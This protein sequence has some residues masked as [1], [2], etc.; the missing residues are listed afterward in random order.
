VKLK[1]LVF[2]DEFG[3]TTHMTRRYARGPRGKRIVCKTPHGHWKLLSTIAAMSVDGIFTACTFDQAIDTEMFVAFTQRMLVPQ[4]RPGQVVVM[5]N[6][7]AHRS[8]KIDALIEAAGARV[9]RLPAYSP[10][11]N[12]IEMAISKIKALLRKLSRRTF[13]PLQEA[14]GVAI[15]S[16]TARDAEHFMRHC[17]YAATI[18]RKTL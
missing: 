1:D 4:L 3:A 12:P 6:L 9:L 17:G 7:P 18:E 14:I 10:D 13:D 8:A 2:L 11:F 15:N 16:I 5:D